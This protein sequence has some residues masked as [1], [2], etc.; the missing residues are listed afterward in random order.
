M[1]IFSKEFSSFDGFFFPLLTLCYLIIPYRIRKKY[2]PFP[3]LYSFWMQSEFP[4]QFQSFSTI[5]PSFILWLFTG[6]VITRKEDTGQKD[7][8]MFPNIV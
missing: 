3:L 7:V 5:M 2:P 1:L 8:P 4:L 6:F